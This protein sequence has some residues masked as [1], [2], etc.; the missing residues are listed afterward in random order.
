MTV[1]GAL[2]INPFFYDDYT[3]AAR[4]YSAGKTMKIISYLREYDL[5]AKGLGATGGVSQGEHLRE[6]LFKILH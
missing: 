1:A 3:K 5:K 2:K 6:L 4:N